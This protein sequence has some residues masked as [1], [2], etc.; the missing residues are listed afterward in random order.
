M[1]QPGCMDIEPEPSRGVP[2]QDLFK[3][4]GES[5]STIPRAAH[6]K[7]GLPSMA[8]VTSNSELPRRCLLCHTNI[9]HGIRPT[10]CQQCFHLA[11]TKCSGISHSVANPTWQ[12]TECSLPITSITTQPMM[13]M[14][15]NSHAPTVLQPTT[16]MNCLFLHHTLINPPRTI[17][18]APAAYVHT[19][20]PLYNNL[21]CPACSKTL[22]NPRKSLV[23]HDCMRAFH[24][25]C[26]SEARCAL[27][28]LRE[29]NARR[30][31]SST[32]RLPSVVSSNS[33]SRSPV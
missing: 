10:M 15:N 26:A 14:T 3:E 33:S 19:A 22:A 7:G 2:F 29:Q 1:Q 24:M 5:G 16:N 23:S 18:H 31:H 21:K 25:K 4:T 20:R 27:G 6:Q 17:A 28:R 9:R 32:S 8:S 13:A 12:C 11:H 30:G